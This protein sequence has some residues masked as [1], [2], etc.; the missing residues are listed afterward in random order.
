[1]FKSTGVGV[2]VGIGVG[3]GFLVGLAVGGSVGATVGWAVGASVP[4]E[5]DSGGTE[6]SGRLG[7]AIDGSALAPGAGVTGV[8]MNGVD[9]GP[10]LVHAATAMVTRASPASL[11][12]L[13]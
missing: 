4:G 6:T 13:H 5:I 12:T 2:G 3:V 8:L 1:M 7:S 9:D 11:V 10:T